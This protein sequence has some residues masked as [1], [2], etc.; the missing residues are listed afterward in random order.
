[1]VKVKD[2]AI[3]LS[4]KLGD[5][6]KDDGDGGLFFSVDRLSYLGRAYGKLIRTLSMAMRGYRPGFV[7][8]L[9]PMV[10]EIPDPAPADGVYNPFIFEKPFISCPVKP[11]NTSVHLIESLLTV[12]E[13]FLFNM[14]RLIPSTVP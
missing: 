9:V 14:S 11:L 13:S 5:P 3:E 10:W 12:S 8:P 1:M 2:L 6:R 4:I 7:L